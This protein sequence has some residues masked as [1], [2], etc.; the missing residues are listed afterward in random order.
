MTIN[1]NMKIEEKLLI[2]HQVKRYKNNSSLLKI[3]TLY[4]KCVLTYYVSNIY[5]KNIDL[6]IMLIIIYKMSIFLIFNKIFVLKI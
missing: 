4:Q 5:I 1:N 2:G 3:L 6:Y